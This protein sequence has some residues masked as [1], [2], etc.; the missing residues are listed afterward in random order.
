MADV[1]AGAAAAVD[2]AAAPAAAVAVPASSLVSIV[3]PSAHGQ[4]GAIFECAVEGS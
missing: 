2:G 4:R 3:V 1:L